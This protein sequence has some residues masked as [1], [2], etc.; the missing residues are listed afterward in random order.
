MNPF[1]GSILFCRDVKGR[2]NIMKEKCV[3]I[4]GYESLLRIKTIFSREKGKV[5]ER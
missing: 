1:L 4:T 3:T 2:L 5:H